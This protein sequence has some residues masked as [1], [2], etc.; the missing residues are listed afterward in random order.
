MLPLPS[1]PL[2]VV[3]P[4]VCLGLLSWRTN[5]WGAAVGM[6]V[7]MAVAQ[8]WPEVNPLVRGDLLFRNGLIPGFS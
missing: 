7:G 4:V 6:F 1:L 5:R 3:A 8:L 2:L